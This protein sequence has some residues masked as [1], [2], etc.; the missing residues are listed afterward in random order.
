M[1]NKKTFHLELTQGE[2]NIIL[3]ALELYEQTMSLSKGK[4]GKK[5]KELWD[6]IFDAGLRLRFHD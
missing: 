5:P 4:S 6:K 1:N 2:A 3:L